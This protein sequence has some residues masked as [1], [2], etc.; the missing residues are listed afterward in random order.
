MPQDNSPKRQL[1]LAS[2]AGAIS[3]VPSRRRSKRLQKTLALARQGMK[4]KRPSRKAIN[5]AKQLLRAA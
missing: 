4:R 2:I 3:L 5:V 1:L